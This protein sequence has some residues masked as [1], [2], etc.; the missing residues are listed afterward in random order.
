MN[1]AVFFISYY[2]GERYL[3]RWGWNMG[4]ISR[5]FQQAG[6]KIDFAIAVNEATPRERV[7]LEKMARHEPLALEFCPRE[8][9]YAS[10]NRVLRKH[11]EADVFLVWNIDDVRFPAGALQQAQAALSATPKMVLQSYY[12]L[13]WDWWPCYFRWRHH[14]A[15]RHTPTPFLT[16]NR[17]ALEKVGWFD[18]AFRIS[19]DKEWFYRAFRREVEF[20]TSP[21]VAGILYDAR[22]GLSTSGDPKRICENLVIQE[23]YPEYNRLHWPYYAELKRKVAN[24]DWMQKGK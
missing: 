12:A 19:G 2:R 3:R 11:A 23:Q 15:N 24:S 5:V 18:E 9:V 17:A 22:C 4:R 6:W 8:T 1:R 7:K 13:S 14:E 21:A 20:E 16:F 10:W